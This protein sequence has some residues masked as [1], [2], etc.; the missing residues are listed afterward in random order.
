MEWFSE[1]Y[2]GFDD[3]E[4]DYDK[5]EEGDTEENYISEAWLLYI[6]YCI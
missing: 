3:E 1:D 5:V 6:I 4:F 2:D